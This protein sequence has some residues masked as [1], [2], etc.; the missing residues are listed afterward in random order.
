MKEIILTTS[1]ILYFISFVPYIRGIVK[2]AVKPRP[3]SWLGW[4]MLL[5]IGIFSQILE[6]G[7][8]SSMLIVISAGIGCFAIFLISLF[9]KALINKENDYLCFIL[10]V[11]CMIIYLVSRDAW[12]TTV[13]ALYADLFVGIPTIMNVYKNPRSEDL[14][15]WGLGTAGIFLSFVI[16]LS[17]NGLLIKL[18]PSYMLFFNLLIFILCF[19]RFNTIHNS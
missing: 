13:F 4:S 16:V 12:I 5:G 9:K 6:K 3:L 1:L 19:R 2:G 7:F 15:A 18:Y 10:G 17:E 8:N 11:I 14:L